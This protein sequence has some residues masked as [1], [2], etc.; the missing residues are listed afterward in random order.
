MR[1]TAILIAAVFV[2]ALAARRAEACGGGYDGN[3]IAAALVVGGGYVAATGTFAIK[4]V[5][6]ENHSLGYG[7][8]ET[9]F[10]APF[11]VAYGAG[12]VSEAQNGNFST[13]L[14]A[15]TAL[16]T[17][18]LAHGI[19]TIVKRA[20][21]KPAQAAPPVPDY[22]G[23]PGMYDAPPGTVQVGPVSA[24]VSPAPIRDGAGVGISGTF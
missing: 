18:L 7:V 11:A 14:A 12:F 2:M 3:V 15:M 22:Y 19:Y 21:H 16:H 8:F 20:R 13:P 24:V 4:D 23:P 5:V 17:A 6:T 1:F 9:A 10:N